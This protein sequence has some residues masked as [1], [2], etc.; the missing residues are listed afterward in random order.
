MVDS[1]LQRVR[2]VLLKLPINSIKDK[3][4]V[5][6]TSAKQYLI[7]YLNQKIQI[8]SVVRFVD[9]EDTCMLRYNLSSQMHTYT[10]HGVV[11]ES[12]NGRYTF[13]MFDSVKEDFTYVYYDM[14][15][16]KYYNPPKR[17]QTK[18][19]VTTYTQPVIILDTSIA[20]HYSYFMSIRDV[21]ET[22]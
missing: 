10:G 1:E 15:T 13:K 9:D 8:G 21:D 5:T 11:V 4:G 22:I 20:V 19:I 6:C 17:M 16:G 18:S 3:D 14:L 7:E 2:E 12:N